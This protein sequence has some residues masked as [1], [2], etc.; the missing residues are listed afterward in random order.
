MLHEPE[1]LFLDEPSIGLDAVSK[2]AI[3]GF[4]QELN[5]ERGVTVLLTT[6]DMDDIEAL[7]KRLIVINH[8]TVLLDGSLAHLRERYGAE[9]RVIVDFDG[10]PPVDLPSVGTVLGQEGNRVTFGVVG[11]ATGRFLAELTA[12][13]PV[14]DLVV[15][16]PPIEEL[17]ARLYR[18]ASRA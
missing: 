14:R 17:V 10:A 12:R 3:R 9:R 8:G 11:G 15:E 18:D 1:I 16:P 7:S 5:R 6:H 13:H 4:I 2:L